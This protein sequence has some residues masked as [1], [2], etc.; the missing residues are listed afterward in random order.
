MYF[1]D[2]LNNVSSACTSLR[3]SL[4]VICDHIL[5]SETKHTL[6]KAL[7]TLNSKFSFLFCQLLCF[8]NAPTAL[9]QRDGLIK[10]TSLTKFRLND[11]PQFRFFFQRENYWCSEVTFGKV[12]AS[13]LSQLLRG[14]SEIQNVIHNLE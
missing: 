10:G 5:K 3:N 14:L 11:I 6:R 2:F 1:S 4:K 12:S 7:E 8:F 9:Y 13:R